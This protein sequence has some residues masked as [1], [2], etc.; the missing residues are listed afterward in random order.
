MPATPK[1]LVVDDIRGNRVAMR[2]LLAGIGAELVEAESGAQALSACLDHNFALILLDVQMPDMDGFEVAELL[3][4]QGDMSDTPVIFITANY[5]DEIDRLQGYQLGAVDYLMKPVSE[6]VLLSKVRVFLDLFRTRGQLQV[7]LNTLEM[8]NERLQNEVEERR[9]A[10]AKALHQAFHDPLT[11]LPN[12]AHFYAQLE[13]A[14]AENAN[15]IGLIYLD[16]DGFKQVND[17]HG[18]AAGDALLCAVAGRL[19]HGFRADDLVA[20]LGGDEFAVLLRSLPTES[21]AFE[22]RLAQEAVDQLGR[23]FSLDRAGGDALQVRIGASAGLA[24]GAHAGTS[25]DALVAAAD[26]AMYAAKHAGKGQ[27]READSAG[28]Q[29]DV[30]G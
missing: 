14:L 3:S 28:T 8:T 21:G 15:D 24:F 16:L 2:R 29:S 6:V 12:R 9:R 7:L 18:H 13:A 27:V 19:R 23:P 5:M 25:V 11:D 26:A 17:L 1:I 10:E 22:L 30:S 4:G 20:R